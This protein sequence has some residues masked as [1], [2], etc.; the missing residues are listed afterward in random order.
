LID[1]YEGNLAGA[2]GRNDPMSFDAFALH[3]VHLELA[4]GVIA[5]FTNVARGEAPATAR[6]DGACDLSAGLDVYRTDLDLGLERWE[7]GQA[8]D[9]VRGINPDADDI[10]G[11]RLR[12]LIHRA[13]TLAELLKFSNARAKESRLS[14]APSRLLW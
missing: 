14:I 4:C 12:K 3:L 11:G 13:N 5:D 6:N 9:R 7:A 10:D 8:D 1:E 2:A